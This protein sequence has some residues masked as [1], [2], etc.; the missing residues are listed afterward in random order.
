MSLFPGFVIFRVR[1]FQ[2]RYFVVA[3][4][5]TSHNQEFIYAPVGLPADCDE[6]ILILKSFS[7]ILNLRPFF[8]IPSLEILKACRQGL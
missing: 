2:V 3:T 6:L 8:N 1:Y 4:V 5:E 7:I